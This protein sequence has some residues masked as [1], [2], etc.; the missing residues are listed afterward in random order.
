MD[1]NHRILLG[2]PEFSSFSLSLVL[3]LVFLLLG[4]TCGHKRR[5]VRDQA[6]AEKTRR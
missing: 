5:A 1:K 2:E 6:S 4:L 3:G